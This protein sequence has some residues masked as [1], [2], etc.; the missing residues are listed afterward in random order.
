MSVR[1]GG[2]APERRRWTLV[3]ASSEAVPSSVRRFMQ[4]AR[5]RRLRAALPWAVGVGFL[6]VVALIAWMILGSSLLGVRDVRVDGTSLVTPDEVRTAAA[7]RPGT[8]LARVDLAAVEARVGAL[9]PVEK[10]TVTRDWPGGLTVVVVERSPEAV[11]PHGKRFLV[12]DRFGVVFQEL[13]R[14]PAHLPVVRIA[15]PR[16]D[17]AATRGA[18]EVIAALSPTLRRQLVEVEVPGPAQITLKLAEGRT[19]VWGDATRNA[20]KSIATTALLKRDGKTIDVSD[21]EVVTIR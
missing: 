15:D 19:V 16:A 11:V 21:P 12:V 10:A 17:P 20:D 6:G 7:V 18:V 5:R 2:G 4:R 14:R 13:A 9:A 8:P 3:R 1:P